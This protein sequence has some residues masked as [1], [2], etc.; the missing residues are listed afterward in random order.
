[1]GLSV[2]GV[3]VKYSSTVIN[4]GAGAMRDLI[5]DDDAIVVTTTQA[6][7]SCQGQLLL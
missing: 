3:L 5:D 6:R 4:V 1:M 2:S 7:L